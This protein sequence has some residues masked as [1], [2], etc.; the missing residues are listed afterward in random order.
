MKTNGNHLIAIKY[1]LR[2]EFEQTTYNDVRRKLFH[3]FPVAINYV[4]FN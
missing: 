4:S 1:L 2:K 3:L